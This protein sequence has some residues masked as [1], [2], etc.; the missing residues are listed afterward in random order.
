[1]FDP[2]PAIHL[3]SDPVRNWNTP[4]CIEVPN[5]FKIFFWALI[6]IWLIDSFTSWTFWGP[7]KF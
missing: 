3:K 6:L 2:D 4:F 7:E 1:M 5:A